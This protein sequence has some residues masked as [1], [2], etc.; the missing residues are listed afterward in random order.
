MSTNSKPFNPGHPPRLLAT[1]V[2]LIFFALLFQ[3][4]AVSIYWHLRFGDTTEFH[5]WVIRI[6]SGWWAFTGNDQLVIQKMDRFYQRDESEEIIVGPLNPPKPVALDALKN[7]VTQMYVNK[8]SA[9]QEDRPIHLGPEKGYC[10]HFSP[11]KGEKQFRITCDSLDAQ[12]S[13]DYF[14]HPSDSQT[15]YSVID[16]ARRARVKPAN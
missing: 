10:L 2:V 15:F 12:L 3:P 14:G 11:N 8:G 7:A 6:P 5:G 13:L 9:L 16:Q 4:E 1:I